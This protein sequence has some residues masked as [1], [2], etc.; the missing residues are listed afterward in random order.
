MFNTPKDIKKF[1]DIDEFEIKLQNYWNSGTSS[2]KSPAEEW[3]EVCSRIN[4]LVKIKRE[5]WESMSEVCQEKWRADFAKANGEKGGILRRYRR[6]AKI[7]YIEGLVKSNSLSHVTF[8]FVQFVS[9]MLDGKEFDKST[10]KQIQ[11]EFGFKETR[12]SFEPITEDEQYFWKLLKVEYITEQVSEKRRY[13]LIQKLYQDLEN[14]LSRKDI[15]KELSKGKV[16]K[17]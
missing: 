4:T 7:F 16:P 1:V 12:K 6:Q 3:S 9:A 8:S 15:K 13:Y 10:W 11:A 14:D 2:K 17:I 5:N